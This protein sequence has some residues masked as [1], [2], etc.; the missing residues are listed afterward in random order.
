MLNYL[1]LH[2]KAKAGL[3][4]SNKIKKMK[5]ILFLSIF[6]IIS[7]RGYSQNLEYGRV[8]DTT[9]TYTMNVGDCYKQIN[10]LNTGD[11][12]SPPQGKV[13]KVQSLLFMIPPV[14]S[15]YNSAYMVNPSGTSERFNW[16]DFRALALLRNGTTEEV[17]SYQNLPEE[18]KNLIVNGNKLDNPLWISSGEIGIGVWHNAAM[19]TDDYC[20]TTAYSFYIHLSIIE[21]NE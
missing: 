16:S 4:Q 20:M 7:N 1:D 12:I 14:Y 5:K 11:Y 8:I 13:W 10:Q 15:A 21:F 2:L 19:G 3:K 6:F 17:F 18:Y 9:L